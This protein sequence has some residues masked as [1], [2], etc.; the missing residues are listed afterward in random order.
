MAN[1]AFL[2][3][4]FKLPYAPT[5]GNYST[6]SQQPSFQ[7]RR[8]PQAYAQGESS[9]LVIFQTDRTSRSTCALLVHDEFVKLPDRLS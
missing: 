9:S 3:F 8:S 2:F 7:L 5:H 6:E 4:L 1:E